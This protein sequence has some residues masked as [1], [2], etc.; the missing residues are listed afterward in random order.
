MKVDKTASV[1][2]DLKKV[3]NF[4][5]NTQNSFKKSNK[6]LSQD[7]LAFAARTKGFN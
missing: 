1:S 5:N 4:V 3:F 2:N 7:E 6:K